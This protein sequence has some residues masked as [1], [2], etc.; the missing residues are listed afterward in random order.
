[1]S[2]RGDDTGRAMDRPNVVVMQTEI[3]LAGVRY[4]VWHR[5]R[6]DSIVWEKFVK[7]GRKVAHR[8]GGWVFRQAAM[9]QEQ[10]AL[11]LARLISREDER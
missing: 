6:P 11:L 5:Q 2:D 4:K 1:M 3:E 9:E 10:Q 8:P 7:F